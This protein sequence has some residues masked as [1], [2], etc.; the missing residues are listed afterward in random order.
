[1][2]RLPSQPAIRRLASARLL[3]MASAEGVFFVGIWGR[4]AFELQADAVGIAQLM[5]GFA[6]GGIAGGLLAGPLVDRVGPRPVLLGAEAAMVPAALLLLWTPTLSSLIA[7]SALW[8]A[9]GLVAHTAMAA[10]APFF[11]AGEQALTR[12]NALIEQAS[13]LAFAIGP[14][15]AA[16]IQS[17][18]GTSALFVADA[19]TSALAVGVLL[20]LPEQREPLTEQAA[21]PPP[22]APEPT[23]VPWHPPHAEPPQSPRPEPTAGP[24]VGMGR[25]L[26]DALAEPRLRFPLLA[27]MVVFVS[28]G[29]FG[30]LEPLF[31]RDVLG[32]DP[33]AIGWVNSLVGVGLLVGTVVVLRAG[34]R[35]TRELPVLVLTVGSGVG[36][37]TY[38]ATESLTVVAVS[39]VG[40][41]LVL[42][43]LLP[44][45]RTLVQLA[46]PASRVGRVTTIVS[47]SQT[48]GDLLPLFVAPAAATAFGVQPTLVVSGAV[49]IALAVALLPS[50]WTLDR[51]RPVPPPA[52]A[53]PSVAGG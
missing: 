15:A 43:V 30:A 16:V 20:P 47:V 32:T 12:A 27:G 8:A 11:V 45:L 26:V 21:D 36:A 23:A 39:A 49:A 9:V 33:A 53:G 35:L 28:F 41:G 22:E 34:A 44:T 24:R 1:M 38:V 6:V 10:A 3:S 4:A 5:F 18:A 29:M 7:V 42:G 14:A 50:A 52:Q 37:V 17:V 13:V 46:A 31:F 51:S 19:V 2:R 40:W 48:G 25:V